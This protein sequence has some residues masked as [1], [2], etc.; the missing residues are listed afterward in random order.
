[1]TLYC[2]SYQFQSFIF[3]ISHSFVYTFGSF[4]KL[5]K[6]KLFNQKRQIV[7]IIFIL[8]LFFGNLHQFSIHGLILGDSNS[9]FIIIYY[10]L[11][12]IFFAL[13]LKIQDKYI[14][15]YARTP[16][17]VDTEL[18]IPITTMLI[19]YVNLNTLLYN[20]QYID[21]PYEAKF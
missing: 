16:P 19:S 13:W 17:K 18:S 20:D 10:Y 4:I 21:E 5:A 2:K 12:I 9:Y 1:M 7:I 11:F 3:I 15:L 6:S 14:Y 8:C